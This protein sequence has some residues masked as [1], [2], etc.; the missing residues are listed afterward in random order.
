M[1]SPGPHNFSLAALLLTSGH[2]ISRHHFELDL[3]FHFRQLLA[4]H[5]HK[6]PDLPEIQRSEQPHSHRPPLGLLHIDSTACREYRL[7]G[8]QLLHQFPQ[9]QPQLHLFVCLVAALD[10]HLHLRQP[11]RHPYFIRKNSLVLAKDT[12]LTESQFTCLSGCDSGN[13][14]PNQCTR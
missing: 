4:E 12:V 10:G 1:C 3:P 13:E 14:Y 5:G 2:A 11:S 6:I 8:L 9:L 7:G